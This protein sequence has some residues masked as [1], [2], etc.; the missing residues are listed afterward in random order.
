[1]SAQALFFEYNR[2]L[3]DRQLEPS[4]FRLDSRSGARATKDGVPFR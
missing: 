4:A 3:L 2:D 1:M